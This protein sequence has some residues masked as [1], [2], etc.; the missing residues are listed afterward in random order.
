M[1]YMLTD[2]KSQLELNFHLITNT[3][4]TIIY[5]MLNFIL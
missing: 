4:L 5:S 3:V 2:I 1:H